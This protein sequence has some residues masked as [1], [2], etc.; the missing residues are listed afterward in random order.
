[1][2]NAI[3]PSFNQGKFVLAAIVIAG[4]MNLSFADNMQPGVPAGWTASGAYG[5]QFDIGIDPGESADGQRALYIASKGAGTDKYAA[6]SQSIDVTAWQ[7]K[8][9]VFSMMARVHDTSNYG[10]LWMRGTT[11]MQKNH[12]S[13]MTTNIKG[14]EWKEHKL[15]MLIPPQITQLEF[16]IGLRQQGKMWVRN[17]KLEAVAVV[18]KAQQTKHDAIADEVP[19][20][21]AG[22]GM[23]NLDFAQ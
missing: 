7:G 11:G 19:M 3:K 22:A 14:T 10:E 20:H 12:T 13:T 4:A 21:A 18:P 23:S 17:L 6:L 16:G 2:K 8:T 5:E 9:V 1:M 15:T